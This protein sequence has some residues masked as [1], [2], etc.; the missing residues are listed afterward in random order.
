MAAAFSI[1]L[2]K[3]FRLDTGRKSRKGVFSRGDNA[4]FFMKLGTEA[5]FD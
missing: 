3:N 2:D 1:T 4:A 5:E